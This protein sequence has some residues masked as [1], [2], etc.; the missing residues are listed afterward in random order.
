[1]D[2][3]ERIEKAKQGYS[4]ELRSEVPFVCLSIDVEDAVNTWVWSQKENES[5]RC[6][7]WRHQH[8]SSGWNHT[9]GGLR[10]V[11]VCWERGARCPA[12]HS[13]HQQQQG[14]GRG[15]RPH[16]R[17]RKTIGQK[18]RSRRILKWRKCLTVSD[19]A[20]RLN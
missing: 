6:R 12:V 15:V 9:G 1:M 4:E 2:L 10:L 14:A 11:R 8:V 16:L 18:I 5:Q 20:E 3:R 13:G 17:G 7:C 19:S